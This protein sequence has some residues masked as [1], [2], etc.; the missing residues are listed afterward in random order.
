MSHGN[1]TRRKTATHASPTHAD[2]AHITQLGR[3]MRGA[4]LC[5]VLAAAPGAAHRRSARMEYDS[6]RRGKEFGDGG[7]DG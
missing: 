1:A 2:T 7:V 5:P 4:G 6:C 3:R